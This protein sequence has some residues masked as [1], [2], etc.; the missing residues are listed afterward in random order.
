MKSMNDS[1]VCAES[2]PPNFHHPQLGPTEGGSTV[3]LK[4]SINIQSITTEETSSYVFAEWTV[5]K[6]AV[7]SLSTTLVCKSKSGC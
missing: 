2:T 1:A 4:V 7:C 5:G 6:P 3:L